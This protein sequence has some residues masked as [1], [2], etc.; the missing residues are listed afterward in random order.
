MV[1]IANLPPTEEMK[2]KDLAHHIHPFTDSSALNADKLRV[3]TQAQGVF[4]YDSTGKEYLDGMSGLWC[5]NIGYGHH[6]I[7][8]VVAQ[9]MKQLPFYNTLFNT[10]HPGIIALSEKLAALTPKD[11]TRFFYTGGGSESND[12]ILRI[13][14]TYWAAQGQPEKQVVIA[15]KNAYH[16][17]SY[18]S[19]SLGGMQAMHRQG[20]LPIPGIHH[21]DQ[22]YWFD[23]GGDSDINAFGV[24]RAQALA[25]AIDEI[26]EDKVAAFIAEP[27]QGAGGAIPPASYW[28]EIRRIC[29]ERDILLISDEVICGFGRL[30]EWFGAQYFNI[31]PHIITMAKGLTSGYL[32]MGAVGVSEKIM[33]GMEQAGEFLHGYTY[34]GHPASAAAALEVIAIMEREHI[35]ETVKNEK[36]A[37]W[38]ET[39]SRL[40]EHPLVGEAATIG[41][42]GKLELVPDA[43]HSRR[44]FENVGN[45]G[46]MCRDH[47]FDSGVIM[48][49]VRDTMVSA[50][51]LVISDKDMGVLV[52]RVWQALDKTMNDVKSQMA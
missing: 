2:A 35:V 14:R 37:R 24:A 15:R 38:T 4:V 47:C 20:G 40:G 36:I 42:L 16:G 19:A 43:R 21:I 48:R 33:A 10:T 34:S 30:G 50:P 27:V 22:P 13:V 31:R 23:E 28:P 7:A 45:V 41:M 29:D 49:A 9:Q 12:T 32:P 5:T 8:D 44:R 26:G 6:S 18:A 11:I 17:S 3:M 46:I 52:T 51:P 1:N 39:F 25:T